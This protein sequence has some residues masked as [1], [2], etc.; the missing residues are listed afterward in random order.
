MACDMHPLGDVIHP[1]HGCQP[2]AGC[3]PRA[4]MTKGTGVRLAL[5]DCAALQQSAWMRRHWL[6]TAARGGWS[7]CR[8]PCMALCART[9]VCSTQGQ[10]YRPEQTINAVSTC[11]VNC[12]LWS[13]RSPGVQTRQPWPSRPRWGRS[14]WQ[15]SPVCG[16]GCASARQERGVACAAGLRMVTARFSNWLSLRLFAPRRA[17]SVLRTLARAL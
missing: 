3:R 17:P 11:S 14:R 15:A 6:H 10:C 12:Q 16:V 4:P 9:A 5:S 7:R 1:G 13:A 2:S 8:Q